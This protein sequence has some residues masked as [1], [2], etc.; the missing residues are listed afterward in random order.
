[1]GKLQIDN[2]EIKQIGQKLQASP[3]TIPKAAKSYAKSLFPLTTWIG[4]YNRSWFL[5]DMI[6]GFTVGFLVVPQSLA[7]ARIATLPVEYGLYTAFAGLVVYA[8]FATAKDVTI[9]PTAVLSL[10]TSQLLVS[11]NRD[12]AGKNIYPPV[13]FA[14]ALAFLA[15]IY[16]M[17]IGLF[18]LGIIV[19]FIPS[20]VITGFTTGAA[21]TVIIGQI[22]KLFGIKG[23]D[24]NTQPTHLIVRDIFQKLWT[25][26]QD[27]AFGLT[28]CLF[29]AVLKY[30]A[31]RWG[32][33]YRWIHF[34][35]LA[36][37]GLAL[38]LYV[39]ISWGIFR[40]QNGKVGFALVG[41]V[42][43]GFR[44]LQAPNLEAGMLG[45]IA[46]PAVLTAVIGIVEHIAITKS[47]GRQNGYT[48]NINPN[49]EVMALG[50][51]NILG[52][53]LGGYPATGSFSRSAVKAASGV[54]TPAAGWITGVIVVL[55]LYVL[56]PIFFYIP[57]AVLSAIIV[58]SMSDL[59]ARYPVWLE[60]WSTG[61]SDFTVAVVAC[62]VTIFSSIENGIYSSVGLAALILLLRTARPKVSSLVKTTSSKNHYVPLDTVPPEEVL[63]TPNGIIVIRFGDSLT[64]PNVHYV[65]DRITEL[66]RTQTTFGGVPRPANDRLW[67]D[68]TEERAAKQSKFFSQTSNPILRAVVFDFSGVAH[69]DAAGF[70]TLV[71]FRKEASRYAGRLVAFHFVG[72]NEQVYRLLLRVV[73]SPLAVTDVF[74]GSTQELQETESHVEPSAYFHDNVEDAVKAASLV[75]EKAGGLS[76]NATLNHET[77]HVSNPN[78]VAVNV[79]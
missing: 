61:L 13:V 63:P 79:V 22:P 65:T 18:R 54:R 26:K 24:T 39:L 66:V 38:V 48:N 8:F 36:R 16:E 58:V 21:T 44:P 19:D 62:L 37:N 74:P 45:R 67:C 28:C 47:F 25:T 57:E 9:G 42:P 12:A 69:L 11:A 4:R 35:G 55:A 2:T 7:Q 50:L 49:Q 30:S 27:A 76:T 33:R 29:L 20:S 72:A 40:A 52:S 78:E 60:F 5:G 34:L 51:T 77:L 1:M 31:A 68:D 6:A 17:F 23:I 75:S 53:F 43:S 3:K 56:T 10:F 59:V 64:Y 71:D 73:K 14:V 41:T 15:G 46:G 70:Q 32:R